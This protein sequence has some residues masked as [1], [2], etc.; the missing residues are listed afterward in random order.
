[1]DNKVYLIIIVWWIVFFIFGIFLGW[2]YK[3]EDE[4]DKTLQVA[5]PS[6]QIK[7]MMFRIKYLDK[8][9]YWI[10]EKVLKDNIKILDYD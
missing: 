10:S 2:N 6:G 4:S 8:N 1:M 5:Y 9:S 7:S 3:P